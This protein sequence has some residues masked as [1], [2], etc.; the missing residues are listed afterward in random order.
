VRKRTNFRA[1]YPCPFALPTPL[2]DM[3][4]ALSRFLP[5]PSWPETYAEEYLSRSL[6]PGLKFFRASYPLP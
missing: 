5:L 4:C 1:S 6:P 3:L 2:G